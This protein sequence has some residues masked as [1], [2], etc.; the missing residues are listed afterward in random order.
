MLTLGQDGVIKDTEGNIVEFNHKIFTKTEMEKI[1]PSMFNLGNF[2]IVLQLFSKII[3]DKY[4]VK[5]SE[6]SIINKNKGTGQYESNGFSIKSVPGEVINPDPVNYIIMKN[7]NDYYFTL[8]GSSYRFLMDVYSII[9]DIISNVN[10]IET[11][12]AANKARQI[13]DDDCALVQFVEGN[14]VKS[15]VEYVPFKV[16]IIGGI[17]E[18]NTVEHAQYCS[19]LTSYI[20]EL[21]NRPADNNKEG[22]QNILYK[23]NIFLYSLFVKYCNVIL[24]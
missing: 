18:L 22:Y 6:L 7:F 24:L 5:I 20:E 23:Y 19:I 4:P 21:C 9:P 11:P 15:M 8:K 14:G 16:E 2:P 1:I 13:S 3:E 17:I 12:E 10:N